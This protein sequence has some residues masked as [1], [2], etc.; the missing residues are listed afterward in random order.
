MTEKNK[1]LLADIGKER[2][3]H[4]IRVME[5]AVELGEIY[6]AD[7]NKIKK[8]ALYHDCGKITSTEKIIG[9][10]KEK[11]IKITKEDLKSPEVLHTNLGEYLAKNKYKIKDQDILNAIKYHTT[12]RAG[13]SLI[14]KIIYIADYIEPGRDFN[15][16]E[17]VRVES[18]IN[19]ENSVLM[20][21]EK[22]ISYLESK[23][24][25]IHKNTLEA[26]KYIKNRRVDTLKKKIESNIKSIL[27]AA[28]DK[29]AY[30]YKLIDISKISSIADY[31]LI[32]SAGNTKQ[33]EAIA[34]NI[35]KKMSEEE[36]RI[37]HKEGYRSGKWILLD[38]NDIVVHIFVKEERE[39]YNIEKI[40][41]D[42]RDI[43]VEKFGIENWS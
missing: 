39:K 16:V 5:I 6:K 41:L 33:A 18:K 17:G 31:F 29:K 28:S 20:A 1:E 13:M 35:I 30:N 26:Y 23:N 36:I 37:N 38:Y 4:S 8:A 43:N 19:L 9:I 3:N 22:T 11:N 40:W 27:E 42:G 10:V 7:I 12:G 24:K 32:C 21:L 25:Y 2:Y 34:D 15:G 14:E